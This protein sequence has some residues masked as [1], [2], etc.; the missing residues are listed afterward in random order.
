MLKICSTFF[1]LRI[2]MPLSGA[3]LVKLL[4]ESA[5]GCACGMAAV[6][7][8]I[9]VQREGTIFAGRDAH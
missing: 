8:S 5:V 7:G 4:G 9:S 3:E 6:T 2:S 1:V